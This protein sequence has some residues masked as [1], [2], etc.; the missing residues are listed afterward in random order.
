MIIAFKHSKVVLRQDGTSLVGEDYM[1][2]VTAHVKFIRQS[3]N[4]DEP[5]P[6]EKD[7]TVKMIS[8]HYKTWHDPMGEAKLSNGDSI[9]QASAGGYLVCVHGLL[10]VVPP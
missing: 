3:S 7:C 1:A 8:T 2:S 9:V 10:V 5:G 6:A 4:W